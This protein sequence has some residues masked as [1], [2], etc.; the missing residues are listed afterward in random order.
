MFLGYFEE[1]VLLL[2][3]CK[4]SFHFISKY[5]IFYLFYSINISDILVLFKLRLF[6]LKSTVIIAGYPWNYTDMYMMYITVM[7]S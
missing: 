7:Y 1:T 4:Y 6:S 5:V 3:I 2:A